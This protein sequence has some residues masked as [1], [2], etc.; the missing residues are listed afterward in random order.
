MNSLNIEE[1][2][3]SKEFDSKEIINS[4]LDISEN[5]IL[6]LNNKSTERLN[7]LISGI[8]DKKLKIIVTSENCSISNDKILK[9]KNYDELF[10][11]VLQKI[12]PDYINKNY[13]GITGTNGKTTAGFYLHQLISSRSIFIGATEEDVFKKITN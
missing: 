8:V 6:F 3:S 12:C 7:Q 4:T 2:T 5:S 10:N 11:K 13:Y 9:V 1:L